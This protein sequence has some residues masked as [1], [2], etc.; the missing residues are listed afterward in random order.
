M[1]LH[2]VGGVVLGCV[3]SHRGIKVGLAKI[4]V[5]E[6]LPPPTYVKGEW[7]F[8]GYAGFYHPFIKDFS[9]IAKTITQLSVKDAHLC[10]PMSVLRNFIR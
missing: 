1:P 7:S 3:I 6:L 9:K 4:E 10:L 8:L 5:I 2:S